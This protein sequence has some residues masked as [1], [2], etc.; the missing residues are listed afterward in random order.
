MTKQLITRVICFLL[1]CSLLTGCEK[2]EHFH[3]TKAEKN[4]ESTEGESGDEEESVTNVELRGS[5][6]FNLEKCTV[7]NSDDYFSCDDK[8]EVS[9]VHF[10]FTKI[11]VDI[12]F[13]GIS[14][15]VKELKLNFSLDDEGESVIIHNV[16][17]QSEYRVLIPRK[18]SNSFKLISC[19][20]VDSSE[21]SLGGW[22]EFDT[23]LEMVG[24]NTVVC[25]KT[26]T[27]QFFDK[28]YRSIDYREMKKGEKTPITFG[29]YYCRREV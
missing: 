5:L 8:V 28:Y 10:R 15:C 29:A 20:V 6:D 16:Y 26:G 7:K 3:Y 21:L 2:K 1:T 11:V 22:Q 24:V 4:V 19:E 12:A 27:Y 17:P 25:R 9:G 18:D 14:N 23:D 13:S